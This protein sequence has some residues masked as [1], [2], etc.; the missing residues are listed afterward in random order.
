MEAPKNGNQAKIPSSKMYVPEK[1]QLKVVYSRNDQVRPNEAESEPP[2]EP[3]EPIVIPEPSVEPVKRYYAQKRGRKKA[4]R[5][6]TDLIELWNQGLSEEAIF[7]TLES[8][9]MAERRCY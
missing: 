7:Q 2:A 4:D 3:K 9:H 6:E 8:W 1:P 5:D